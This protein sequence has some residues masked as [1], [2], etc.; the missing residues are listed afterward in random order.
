MPDRRNSPLAVP[1]AS[2][3]V[4]LALV[5]AL[6]G[7]AA[8]SQQGG[9]NDPYES[10]NRKTH[11]FNKGID[12]TFFG[13]GG[14]KGLI[15]TLPKPV[16]QG[17]SNATANLRGPSNVLNR[18]LQGRPGP[19]ISET[20]RFVVNTTVGIGGLFDASSAIGLPRESTD[21]GETLAV[22][23]VGEGAYLEVPFL[24][25]ST[26]RDFAGTI[27]D[28]V[29]DPVGAVVG[30]PDSYYVGAIR[31]GGKIGDRQRFASTYE[32]ILYGSAD[33]Y[34]QSRL[35]YLQNRRFKTGTGKDETL[36]DPYE[37]PYGQ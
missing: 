33:S 23:G 29:T 22:W 25:P 15:P 12:Q 18:A 21:F 37:D 11:A 20:F 17:L 16:A 1:R 14:R 2:Q 3:T 30:E 13:G 9:V 32:S 10:V 36:I 7:C 26:E 5:A 34:A 35:L 19:A 28:I 6:A 31:L 8:T 24:G 4:A 27:V